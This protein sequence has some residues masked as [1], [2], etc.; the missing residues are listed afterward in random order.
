M[1]PPYVS[2][3][4]LD[5]GM[6]EIHINGNENGNRFDREDLQALTQ[7][8][9]K[10][11]APDVRGVL[12]THGGEAFCLGG[13]LGDVRTHHSGTVQCFAAALKAALLAIY[14]C[15][16]PVACAVEGNV[17]GGGVS[18]VEA[19]DLAAVNQNTTFAIPE[20]LHN[21]PPVVSFV[22]AGRVVPMKRLM[23][24]AL[25]GEAMG[26][27]EA[28]R[29]GLATEAVEPGQTKEACLTWLLRISQRN[30]AAIKTIRTMRRRMDGY[31]FQRQ[32]DAAEEQLVA[33]VM[34]EDTRKC[35]NG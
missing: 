16:V 4:K 18:L 29:I 17:A 22:G 32:L 7:A 26:A 14:E 33:V 25:M 19:C 23:Q 3:W 24:M 8:F 13:N 2:L 10:A 20:I 12:L 15:P 6:V 31:G 5:S 1:A 28:T 9:D 11:K 34:N 35:W 21:M 27:R 30:P